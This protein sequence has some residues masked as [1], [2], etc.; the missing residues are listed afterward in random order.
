MRPDV[1]ARVFPYLERV[2]LFPGEV[3]Y[4]P[5]DAM[6][7]AYFPV[8]C[9]ASLTYITKVGSSAE[10]SMVGN[11]GLV[12]IALFMGGN[13]TSSRAI[14]QRGGTAYRLP[15]AQLRAEFDRHEQT[16][17]LLLRYT[18]ALI[19]QMAQ[20]VACNKHHEIEQ[21]LCRWLLHSLDRRS[22]NQLSVTQGLIADMLGVRRES[23]TVAACKLQKLGL[24]EY[25]RGKITVLNRPGL[26]RLSC[27]CYAVVKNEIDR[28][29]PQQ[30]LSLTERS[31]MAS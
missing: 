4:E 22:T 31:A 20:T 13:S 3:L 28:L 1:Q 26:E 21:Q 6:R 14:V 11:E 23:V 17:V 16:S 30:F 7:H 9:I 5:G 29:L 24:I 25:S 18:Q 10:I 8:A 15:A 2:S 27:E 19:T 12:G